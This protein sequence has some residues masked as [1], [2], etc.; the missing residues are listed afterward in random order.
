MNCRS[1]YFYKC[2]CLFCC[3]QNCLTNFSEPPVISRFRNIVQL[4]PFIYCHSL[5][6]VL[7]VSDHLS[8]LTQTGLLCN[9]AC[10]RIHDSPP[11]IKSKK[12]STK[13]FR[14][15]SDESI[16]SHSRILNRYSLFCVYF[17]HDRDSHH[18]CLYYD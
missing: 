15:C 12:L 13:L 1:G 8:P 18:F 4:T 2:V 7:T 17:F 11:V 3:F 16:I 5:R 6:T 10:V 14:L 9:L